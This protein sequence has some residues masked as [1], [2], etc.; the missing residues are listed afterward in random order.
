MQ[1]NPGVGMCVYGLKSVS[2]VNDMVVFAQWTLCLGGTGSGSCL[3][4]C[5]SHLIALCAPSCKRMQRVPLQLWWHTIR[6]THRL[7]IHD[8]ETHTF[9]GNNTTSFSITI[10]IVYC[11]CVQLHLWLIVDQQWRA[12]SS[13]FSSSYS[14]PTASSSWS[15]SAR[16]KY[17][18]QVGC[19]PLERAYQLS[20]TQLQLFW[21]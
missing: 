7:V 11:V 16:S 14:S 17:S 4:L 15:P 8:S 12:C 19:F 21:G 2:L 9:T 10:N 1:A 13:D 5:V 20:I 3:P 18:H 6:N